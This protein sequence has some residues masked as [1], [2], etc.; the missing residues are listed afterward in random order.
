MVEVDSI[1]KYAEEKGAEEAEV[2]SGDSQIKFARFELGEPKQVFMGKSTEYALRVV[3]NG[4]RGFSYFTG[5]W[6]DAVKEA[7]S[8]ARTRE[9]DERWR[10]FSGDEPTNLNLNLYRKS[11]DDTP[12]EKIMSDITSMNE[13][14]K[15][16]KIVASNI[17]C[18]L[19]KST[20]EI[21]NTSGLHKKESSSL[22]VLQVMCRAQDADYGMAHSYVY[23]LGYDFNLDEIGE[24]TKEKALAQLGKKKIEPGLKKVI[25]S[26]KVFSSLVV[27]AALPSFLGD[28]VVEGRSSLF[29]GKEVAAEHLQVVE[30]PLVES[31]Q[32]RVF[33]GEGIPSKRVDLF[34]GEVK[35]FLYDTYYGET[36]GSGIRYSRYRGKNLRDPPKP[37]ATSLTVK[38]DKAPLNELISQVRD[39]L[40]VTEETNSHASK[41]QS[42]L[43]S[44]AV[45]SGFI[46]KD[47]ELNSPV[48][49]CMVSGLA[50]EDL[51][52]GISLIS[53]ERE[54]SRSSVY[55]TYVDTG[56]VLVDSLRITA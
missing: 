28:N 44:I 35:A 45:T 15:D 11:V 32:G 19:G 37:C 16:E 40:L 21:C 55:P 23:S 34:C 24:K 27:S 47:G 6:E 20:V 33:D 53:R 25:L 4:S 38:G 39:G 13:H 31:P 54:L 12:L 36:T 22:A 42:G 51:L 18:Q 41:P 52:P 10:S 49:R 3:V 26:P 5:A 9:K 48:G 2:I 17:V 7:V 43:F 30:D 14:M 1:L 8:L 56:Y 46:I 50:F 29:L